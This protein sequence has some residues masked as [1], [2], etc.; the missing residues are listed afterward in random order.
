MHPKPSFFP[1]PTGPNLQTPQI[2]SPSP[3][4]HG[5][6]GLSSEGQVEKFGEVVDARRSPGTMVLVTAISGDT[7]E[8][9]RKRITSHQSKEQRDA[10]MQKATNLYQIVGGIK[11]PGHVHVHNAYL[12]CLRS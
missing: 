6:D 2:Q 3:P 4:K 7:S 9:N 8:S 5:P 12:K 10:L 11:V 1:Q